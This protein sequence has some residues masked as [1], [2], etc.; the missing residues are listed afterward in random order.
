[1][2][3]ALISAK[4]AQYVRIYLPCWTV[5]LLW[6]DEWESRNSWRYAHVLHAIHSEVTRIAEIQ[7][8]YAQA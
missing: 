3:T 8:T 5:D 7:A 2:K 4:A 1:M 6:I